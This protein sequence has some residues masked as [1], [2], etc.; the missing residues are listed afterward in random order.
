M[1]CTCER[2][3]FP[4]VRKWKTE[5]KKKAEMIDHDIRRS[6][7]ARAH[8]IY[9][10]IVSFAYIIIFVTGFTLYTA[11]RSLRLFSYPS[12]IN[13]D[14]EN[15]KSDCTYIYATYCRRWSKCILWYY[16][17]VS[18]ACIIS[19]VTIIIVLITN[20]FSLALYTHRQEKTIRDARVSQH[21][22]IG[23]W[24]EK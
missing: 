3:W 15:R 10:T 23:F 17:A 24:D 1:C 13:Q 22:G 9:T 6:P 16:I 12:R 20:L 18:L 2:V 21:L 7:T 5:N 4:R 8:M 19:L 11:V 14:I